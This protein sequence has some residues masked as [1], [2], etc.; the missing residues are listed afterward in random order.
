METETRLEGEV[1]LGEKLDRLVRAVRPEEAIKILTQGAKMIVDDAK[2]RAVVGPTGNLKKSPQAKGLSLNDFQPPIALA[3]INRKRAPH[4]HLLEFGTGDRIAKRGKYRG[5]HFGIMKAQPFF[6]PA[7]KNKW[8][9]VMSYVLGE[10]KN[11]I[12]REIDK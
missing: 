3:T 4:A 7:V 1:E 8:D 2:A 10:L 11:R 12:D 9:S 5:K 6:W